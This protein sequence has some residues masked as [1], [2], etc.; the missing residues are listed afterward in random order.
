M[1]CSNVILQNE[2]VFY[3]HKTWI[4]FILCQQGRVGAED[5][6]YEQM[7]LFEHHTKTIKCDQDCG[8]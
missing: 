7:F 2:P 5:L 8:G 3:V 1:A 4:L 6:Q